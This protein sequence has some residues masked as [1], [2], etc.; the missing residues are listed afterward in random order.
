MTGY[1]IAH[2]SQP[3]VPRAAP[4]R[5][6]QHPSHRRSDSDKAEPLTR[7]EGGYHFIARMGLNGTLEESKSRMLL[8]CSAVTSGAKEQ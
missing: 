1:S 4:D 8:I 7:G 2:P 5:S 6:A 3:P